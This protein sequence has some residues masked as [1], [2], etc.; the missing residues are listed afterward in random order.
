MRSVAAVLCERFEG[1]YF[2]ASAMRI[3]A[4]T[5]VCHVCK[6]YEKMIVSLTICSSKDEA[7]RLASVWNETYRKDGKLQE[8]TELTVH[9]RREGLR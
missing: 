3:E 1:G 6:K 8:F 7:N 9:V 5:N 2:Y 4:G